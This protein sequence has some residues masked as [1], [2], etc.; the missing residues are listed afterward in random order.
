MRVCSYNVEWFDDLFEGND[1]SFSGEKK[2]NRLR[3]EAIGQVLREIDADIYG[4]VEAPNTIIEDE[5]ESTIIK[6]E[7]FLEFV[8]LSNYSVYFDKISAGRQELAL[9]YKKDSVIVESYCGGK[10]DSKENPRFIDD[11]IFDTDDDKVKELYKLYRPPLEARIIDKKTNYEFYI[12]LCH[13]KSKG[14]FNSVDILH[15]EKE[16]IRNRRKLIA[17]CSWIRRHILELLE[18]EKDVLVLGDFNDGPGMDSFE[19]EFGKSAIELVM[20]DIYDAKNIL[21]NA[22]NKPEWDNYGWKPASTSFKDTITGKY[23]NVLIDHILFSQK[24]NNYKISSMVWNPYQY[25]DN[26]L[27]SNI[28]F[29]LKTASDHFPVSVDFNF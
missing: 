18:N 21:V 2:E 6:L 14:I 10:K 26:A 23:V 5:K 9:L 13:T 17:E 7:K 28:V 16:N 24:M 19:F 27:L 8:N 4:I 12:F 15:W 29:S 1:L 25:K 3:I 22:I 11:F 20:G